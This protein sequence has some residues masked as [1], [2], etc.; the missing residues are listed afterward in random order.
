MQ[1]VQR[2]WEEWYGDMVST[3]QWSE[4]ECVNRRIL[5]VYGS[6]KYTGDI[7]A[8]PAGFVQVIGCMDSDVPFSE[9]ER[10][11]ISEFLRSMHRV[12]AIS[13]WLE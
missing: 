3:Y 2:K 13:F 11:E 12:D 7:G 8:L 5:Y 10:K 1:D 9:E 4:V 6:A